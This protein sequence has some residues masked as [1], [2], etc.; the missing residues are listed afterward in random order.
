M[1]KKSDII[2]VQ[3]RDGYEGNSRY[4]S[5]REEDVATLF[6]LKFTQLQIML[7]NLKTKD[8]DFYLLIIFK[9]QEKDSKKLDF[10]QFLS[11]DYLL[12]LCKMKKRRLYSNSSH[13]FAI[14]KI[15]SLFIAR[16]GKSKQFLFID[17]PAW[18]EHREIKVD[19]EKNSGC[20]MTPASMDGEKTVAYVRDDE[21]GKTYL[22]IS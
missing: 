8:Q 22:S 14:I 17:I 21:S 5:I 12:K 1:K 19:K 13:T 3:M 10:R 9:I 15:T 18:C 7:D 6:E 4:S 11:F 16:D 20:V 2:I